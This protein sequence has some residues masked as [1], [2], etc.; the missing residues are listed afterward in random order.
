MEHA[1]MENKDFLKQFVMTQMFT[2]YIEEN[3]D[4]IL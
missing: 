3:T 4:A 2:T 1:E